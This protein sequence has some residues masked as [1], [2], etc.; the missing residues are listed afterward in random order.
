[1]EQLLVRVSN[2]TRSQGRSLATQ[3]LEKS[4]SYEIAR[5]LVNL[6]IICLIPCPKPHNRLGN[7]LASI[8][9]YEYS[10]AVRNSSPVDILLDGWQE[11]YKSKSTHR[12]AESDMNLFSIHSLDYTQLIHFLRGGY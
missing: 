6:F 7:I 5:Q 1:M 10:N 9:S 8:N 12:S 11:F 4:K 2:D 3:Y